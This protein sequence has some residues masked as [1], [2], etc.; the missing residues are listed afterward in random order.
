MYDLLY[1]ESRFASAFA[2]L[3]LAGL[4]FGATLYPLIQA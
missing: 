3:L 2:A 4:A 1:R